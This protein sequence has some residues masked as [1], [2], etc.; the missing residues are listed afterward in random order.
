MFLLKFVLHK[1]LLNNFIQS[2]YIGRVITGVKSIHRGKN[3]AQVFFLINTLGFAEKIENNFF[4]EAS[5][6]Q[7]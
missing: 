6:C 3:E 2:F 5:P 1:V 7:K 4:E